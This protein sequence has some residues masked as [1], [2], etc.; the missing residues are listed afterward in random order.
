MGSEDKHRIEMCAS[1]VTLLGPVELKDSDGLSELLAGYPGLAEK[2][3][4]VVYLDYKIL[5]GRVEQGKLSFYEN[6]VFEPKYLK[7]IRIFNKAQELYLWRRADLFRGRFRQDSLGQG[8][9]YVEVKQVLWGSR[10]E[11]LSHGWI[12]LCED[13]GIELILPWDEP[14]GLNRKNPK[15]RVGLLSRNYIDYT[16]TAQAG[17]TDCRFI[18]FERMLRDV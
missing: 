13:R 10:S 4:T 9:E 18:D 6:E 5:I 1:E 2:A 15:D 17:Y 3:K 8:T 11:N 14:D 12:K 16:E 7:Q